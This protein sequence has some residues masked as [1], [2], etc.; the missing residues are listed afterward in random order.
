[1]TT[2]AREIVRDKLGP[3][4]ESAFVLTVHR[5]RE[6]ALLGRLDEA[7]AELEWVVDRYGRQGR[8]TLSVPLY[9]LGFVA[10]LQGRAREAVSLQER[11][12]ASVRPSPRS[13]RSSARILVE[14]GLAKLDAGDRDGAREAMEQARAIYEEKFAARAP[15]YADALVGLGRIDLE[16][17]RSEVALHRFEGAADYWAGLDPESR[18][19]G[20]AQLWLGRACAAAGRLADAETHHARAVAI[21]SHSRLPSDAALLRLARSR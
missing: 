7:R 2:R 11:A 1:V 5:G 15:E 16:E 12:L 6:L 19:A 14:L 20:E 8:A 21:L 17:G 10:R 13:R 9:Q 3:E 4:H 18:W